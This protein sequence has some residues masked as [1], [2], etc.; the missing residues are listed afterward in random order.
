MDKKV[1]N[2]LFVFV[3]VLI[4][5][6]SGCYEEEVEIE[7]EYNENVGDIVS[8]ND[9]WDC[10]TIECVFI[11]TK[12][13]NRITLDLETEIFDV[14]LRTATDGI[15]G[16]AIVNYSDNSISVNP[17]VGEDYT[18]TI[19]GTL[20]CDGHLTGEP[21]DQL[22]QAVNIILILVIKY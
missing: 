17:E 15:Y 5:V 1:K 2:I 11:E 19:N 6:L 18:C 12:Y 21:Y 20:D 8:V 9:E 10:D 7:I 16:K 4:F 13:W 3:A 14:T 22:E